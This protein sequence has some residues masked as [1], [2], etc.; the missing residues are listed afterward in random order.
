MNCNIRIQRSLPKN[1]GSSVC[2]GFDKWE[3]RIKI[4]SKVETGLVVSSEWL[5]GKLEV[6]TV[7]L[8]FADVDEVRLM[9]I[10]EVF[11]VEDI[12][13]EALNVPGESNEGG[14]VRK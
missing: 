5:H 9:D 6:M 8:G 7:D 11:E 1:H 14:A 4:V 13:K 3:F 10:K 2:L 12:P